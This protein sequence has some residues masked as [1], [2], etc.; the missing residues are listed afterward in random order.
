M[1]REAAFEE[2]VLGLLTEKFGALAKSAEGAATGIEKAG[3]AAKDAKLEIGQ[4]ASAP[5]NLGGTLLAAWIM[6]QT[7]SL[8][9]MERAAQDLYAALQ[10]AAGVSVPTGMTQRFIESSDARDAARRDRGGRGT[11]APR[12]NDAQV[13]IMVERQAALTRIARDADR[14]IV[15]SAAQFARQRSNTIANFE[16]SIAREQEDF[17]RQRL[18]AER[19]LQMSILDVAQDSARQRVRWEADLART[20]EEQR[21]ERDERIGEART[22]SAERL[23]EM[24]VREARDREKRQREF[25]KNIREAAANLDA[26][27]VRELQRTRRE[28]NQEAKESHAEKIADEAK[29]LQKRIDDANKS[30]AKQETQQRSALDRRIQQQAEDDRLRIQEMKDAFE[31][32]TAQEDIERGIKLARQAED[33]AA[34]LVEMDRAQGER[35]QQIKDQEAEAREQVNEEHQTRL[36]E[37]GIQTDAWIRKQELLVN[38]AIASHQR[39]WEELTRPQ[40]GPNGQ[41]AG[42]PSLE[43]PFQ[44]VPPVPSTSAN[45]VSNSRTLTGDVNI[46]IYATASQSPVDIAS[47][48]DE[49]LAT[50][51]EGYQ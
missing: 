1:T 3:A 45:N 10:R 35:I 7:E 29:S 24:E 37:V 48:V 4:L 20:L 16:K 50:F 15:D 32:Q 39:F 6:A 27:Q 34:Q 23:A 9:G 26:V 22:D 49:R 46:N 19:K 31:A 21:I 42:F 51:F 11:T 28:E 44:F 17:G 30:Y 18:N 13:D 43:N 33:H 8:R 36:A 38:A 14:A 5:V 47:A 40:I 25:A 2:A 12:F 41:P